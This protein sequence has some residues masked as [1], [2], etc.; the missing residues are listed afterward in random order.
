MAEQVNHPDHYKQ[1]GRDE[2]IVEMEKNRGPLYVAYFCYGSAEKYLYRAGTKDNNPTEQDV[3]KARWY[4]NYVD[5]MAKRYK[6]PGFDVAARDYI[7]KK[8]LKQEKALRKNV[9]EGVSTNE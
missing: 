2:C 7:E 5:E 9:R 3:S 1:E 8:L 4:F 6:T